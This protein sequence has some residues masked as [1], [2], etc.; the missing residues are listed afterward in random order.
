MERTSGVWP[1]GPRLLLSGRVQCISR[2]YNPPHPPPPPPLRSSRLP[3]AMPQNQT[4]KP[5]V[6][7]TVMCD[8]ALP[9]I[10]LVQDCPCPVF[11]AR[12]L[13][14]STAQ[15]QLSTLNLKSSWNCKQPCTPTGVRNTCRACETPASCELFS[16]PGLQGHRA[17]PMCCSQ[18]WDIGQQRSGSAEGDYGCKFCG[19]AFH[20]QH[21]IFTLVPVSVKLQATMRYLVLY[22]QS[23]SLAPELVMTFPGCPRFQSEDLGWL[24]RLWKQGR[25]PAL[26]L[27]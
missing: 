16:P 5:R 3:W 20:K 12:T 24:P 17:A 18:Q 19:V 11:L 25:A 6:H 26:R 10:K 4:S 15:P 13:L 23:S 27:P 14:L 7:R 8:P 21:A 22:P 9:T 1:G 2:S